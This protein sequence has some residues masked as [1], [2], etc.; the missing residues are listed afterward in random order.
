MGWS[1][2]VIC[3]DGKIVFVRDGIEVIRVSVNR[4][5]KAGQEFVKRRGRP[6]DGD[7]EGRHHT[8]GRF[9]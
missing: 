5:L 1:G 7:E 9:R 4:L 2:R 8:R 3:Q 6:R